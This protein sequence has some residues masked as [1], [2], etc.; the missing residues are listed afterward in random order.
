M[1]ALEDN[2]KFFFDH[3][4]WNYNPKTETKKE[5][6]IRCARSLADAEQLAQS[7]GL[8]FRWQDDWAVGDHTRE[9]DYK[10]NPSTCE[11]CVCED[12]E[13]NVL[14]SLSCIDDADDNYR[15][16]V[17]AELALEAIPEYQKIHMQIA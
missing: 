6:R 10:S 1:K 11:S 5:G 7:Y 13:D 12:G 4:G 14:A 17:E 8:Q 16:V 2:V 3:A 9:F 15:R